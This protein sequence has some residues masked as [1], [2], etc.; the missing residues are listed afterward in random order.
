MSVGIVSDE[1]KLY[2]RVP[3]DPTLYRVENDAVRVSTIAF[4]DRNNAVSVDRALLCN[5][6]PKH[7]Q[8]SS[9]DGILVLIA[10]DVRAIDSVR[11]EGV[12]VGANRAKKD[13]TYIFDVKHAPIKGDSASPSNIAHAV[14]IPTPDYANNSAFKKLKERLALLVS[15]KSWSETWEIEPSK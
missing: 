6:D 11:S 1:E 7:T 4:N 15:N 13:I 2:R 3:A 5:H 14:I 12:D 8:K 10:Q 9:T